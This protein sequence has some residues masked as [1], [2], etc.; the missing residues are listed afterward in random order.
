ML[1]VMVAVSFSTSV[2]NV[3]DYVIDNTDSSIGTKRYLNVFRIHRKRSNL[4]GNMFNISYLQKYL[5][6]IA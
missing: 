4:H 3:N 6:I 5:S 1:V 2:N